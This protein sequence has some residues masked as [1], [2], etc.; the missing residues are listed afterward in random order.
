MKPDCQPRQLIARVHRV[1][2]ALRWW[3]A[4]SGAQA[5][6]APVMIAIQSRPNRQPERR[7]DALSARTCVVRR[8]LMSA[9]SRGR[10]AGTDPFRQSDDG[11]S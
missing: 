10:I 8:L 2:V 1:R 6:Q 4:R 3:C 5:R 9:C 11:D 7:D